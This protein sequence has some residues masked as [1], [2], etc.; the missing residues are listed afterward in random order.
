[1]SKLAKRQD[2]LSSLLIIAL[3]VA[4]LVVVGVVIWQVTKT[5]PTKS[6]STT[7][8]GT[9]SSACV[10]AV[11]SSSFCA[12]ATNSNISSKE[13][14]ATGTATTSS[15]QTSSYTVQNDGKGNTEVTYTS[16]GKQISAITLDGSTYLQSGSG[17]TWIEYTGSQSS[18]VSVPNPVS[19][20]N[21]NFTSNIPKGVTVNSEGTAACGSLTCNKYKVNLAS[22]ATAT[23]YVYFDTSNY[24]LRQWTFSDSSTKISV[25]LTF[26]YQSV[27]ITKPSPVQQIST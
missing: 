6:V 8:S 3:V 27:T 2:G 9:N 1:M 20:F 5:S 10:K 19:G 21:L 18:A 17:T 14:I 15:G 22:T 24:L 23:Q 16:A 26:D 12:F 4:V 13:Y 25:N 11:G 7:V